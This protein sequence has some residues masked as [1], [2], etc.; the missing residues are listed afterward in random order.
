MGS[1]FNNPVALH[2]FSMKKQLLIFIALVLLAGCAT[3]KAE[4]NV[5]DHVFHSSYPALNVAVA[6]EFEYIGNNKTEKMGKSISGNPLRYKYDT[7]NF[8]QSD[9]NNKIQKSVIVEFTWIKTHFI[10]DFNKS[11]KNK[12]ESGTYDFEGKKYQYYTKV[13]CP[14]L[15]GR[16]TKYLSERGYIWPSS[17][18][19]RFSRIANQGGNIMF[20][21]YYY[22]SVEKS[23]FSHQSFKNPDNLSSDQKAY[24]KGFNRRALAS[25]N[26]SGRPIKPLSES[27]QTARK[28][29][30]QPKKPET[31]AQKSQPVTV[32]KPS[33]PSSS[34]P[35]IP[36]KKKHK[37]AVMKFQALNDASGGSNLGTM[38]SEMFTTEVVNSDA[39]KIVEREQL[40]KIIDELNVGQSG[41]IDTTEAQ[42]IGKMLGASAIITGSVMK[43]G[44]QLRIDSRIIEVETG[45]IA[46]A[47]S[48]ICKES[49]TDIGQ[50]VIEMTNGLADK[51]YRNH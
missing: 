49:L 51:Y 6:P 44:D 43:M 4:R 39:F 12:L 28:E 19:R 23:G 38:V 1:H 9:Q 5:V 46:G 26:L 34:A 25:F 10:S 15:K 16:T 8:I 47:E 41:I 13:T 20:N 24:L 33:S 36:D 18:L 2:R 48:R 32:S 45:I 30:S 37:I 21:V 29:I 22:E 35:V 40:R 50:K 7:Y 11:V 17:L 14:S 31:H 27:L 3:M 42:Q